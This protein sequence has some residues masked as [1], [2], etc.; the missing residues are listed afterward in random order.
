MVREIGYRLRTSSIEGWE[1]VEGVSGEIGEM[2]VV[3]NAKFIK[4][5]IFLPHYCLNQ[6]CCTS[7]VFLK[8][9]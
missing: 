6:F 1:V 4:D 3:H 2:G 5:L 7:L 9:L 8:P